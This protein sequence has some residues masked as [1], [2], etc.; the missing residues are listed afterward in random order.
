MEPLPASLDSLSCFA[1]FLSRTLTPPSVRNYLHGVK[2]LHLFLDLPTSPFEAFQLS[3]VLKGLSKSHPHTPL[4]P[5]PITPSLLFDIHSRLD[6]SSPLHVT[7]WCAFLLSFFLFARKSNM[8]PPSF[9]NFDLSKHLAR[10]DISLCAAGLSVHLKW[11]KTNQSGSRLVQIPVVSIPGSPL[12]PL[13]AFTTMVRVVPA[14]PEAPAFSLPRPSKR[15]PKCLTHLSFVSHL[16]HLISL[17][18]RDPTGYTGHSFRRG[19]ATFAF[20]AG[21]P[22]ELIQLQGDWRSDAYLR[23]LDFSLDSKLKVSSQMAEAILAGFPAS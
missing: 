5:L 14:L 3:L 10:R 11:S 2:T 15:S 18:G 8:V 9:K 17:T 4:Q 7:L 1:L 12:C 13:A 22:G 21:V 6:L 19:G 23:Y 20:Q 16:R